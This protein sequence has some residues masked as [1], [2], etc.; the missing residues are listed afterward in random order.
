[1]FAGINSVSV[2]ESREAIEGMNSKEMEKVE[3]VDSITIASYESINLWLTELENQMRKCLA[4]LFEKSI[5][6]WKDVEID[7]LRDLV[8]KYPT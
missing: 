4:V 6:D 7:K 8:E 1:M 5:E 3:F 2:S